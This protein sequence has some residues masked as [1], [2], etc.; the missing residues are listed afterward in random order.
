MRGKTNIPPRL[1]PVINGDV[2]NFVVANGNTIAKGD[3]VSYVLNSQYSQ[4]DSR[5]MTLEYKYEYDSVNHKFLL[6]FTTSASY[7][8]AIIMLVQVTQGDVV[9]LDSETVEFAS[10]F[11]GGCLDGNNVYVSGVQSQTVS[12]VNLSVSKYE[13]VNYEIT[14]VQNYSV[15]ISVSLS[16]SAYAYAKGIFVKGTKI[17]LGL[18]Y[19][20]SSVGS[21]YRVYYGDLSDEATYNQYI[22]RISTQYS[23]SVT[24]NDLKFVGYVFGNYVVFIVAFQNASKFD[25][26]AVDTTTQTVINSS[27]S[28]SERL[29]GYDI[30]NSM[31]CVVTTSRII[32]ANFS[33]GVFT[34]LY[35]E[36]VSNSG[37]SSVVGRIAQ[38]KFVVCGSTK[39]RT[40]E[41]G[42][43]IQYV[44]NILNSF[45]QFNGFTLNHILSDYTT[46]IA[47]VCSN[48]NG[49]VKY[50]GSE[51][52]ENGF[53]VGEPTNYVQSYDGG[54]TVGFAK[55]G[56]NAGDTI[57][58]YVPHTS[59]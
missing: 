46:N 41:F 27:V 30:F 33:E 28:Y 42:E 10:T 13:I 29:V 6:A 47:L 18:V 26:F 51:T 17:Y 12:G 23:Y 49:V 39:T 40:F 19:R 7:S 32:F 20:T 56:G 24:V 43:T 45:V 59:S 4:F 50:Y 14:F 25:V 34:V 48:T 44:D 21:N 8:T 55:I 5:K 57:Q 2:R 35:N 9:V 11:S 16:G 58:V 52:E 36:Q 31:V 3:F 22:S 53:V 15:T 1:K 54:F 38:D 37:D